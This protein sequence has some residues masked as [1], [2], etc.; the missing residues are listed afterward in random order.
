M[1]TINIAVEITASIFVLIMLIGS[2][3]RKEKKRG[4]RMINLMFI[5]VFMCLL[6]NATLYCKKEG[7]I[8]VIPHFLIAVLNSLCLYAPVLINIMIL[9]YYHKGM[10]L[11]DK[12]TMIIIQLSTIPFYFLDVKYHTV[13]FYLAISLEVPIIYVYSVSY[14]EG[15]LR[16]LEKEDAENRAS[17]VAVQIHPHFVLNT[18][19]TVRALCRKNQEEAISALDFLSVYMQGVMRTMTK[20]ECIHIKAEIEFIE[21][22]IGIEKLRY[23]KNLNVKY[24]IM[25]IDFE[26]PALCI[27]PLVENAIRHGLCP[28]EEGGDIR[29]AVSEE[30]KAY[31]ILVEDNGIG[32][33]EDQVKNDGRKHIGIQNVRDRLML[34][35]H[36][37]LEIESVK[38]EGTRAWIKIPKEG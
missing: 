32:F 26:V 25:D 28:K 14:Q 4:Y 3:C 22:Y 8:P 37:S 12:I 7:I 2:L 36:G 1:N 13:L 20:Q 30:D 10:P 38:G 17:L 23:G 21:S 19:T 35:K 29:I 11:R 27:Q 33:D 24:E 18:L 15:R 34:S 16:L 9:I 6:C 5:A 31:C